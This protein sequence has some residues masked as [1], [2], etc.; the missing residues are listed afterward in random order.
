M[1]ATICTEKIDIK[2]IDIILTNFNLLT[3]LFND[4]LDLL[5]NKSS[6]L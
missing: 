4:V 6:M 5:F 1:P 3:S 2:G